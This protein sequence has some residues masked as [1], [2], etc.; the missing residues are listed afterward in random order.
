MIRPATSTQWKNQCSLHR[1]SAGQLCLCPYQLRLREAVMQVF[2]HIAV[3][4]QTDAFAI[5]PSAA[6]ELR[7]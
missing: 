3:L 1:A 6:A 7:L 4:G 5:E 2:R